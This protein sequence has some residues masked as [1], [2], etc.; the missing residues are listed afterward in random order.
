MR[1]KVDGFDMEIEIIGT[2]EDWKYNIIA[3]FYWGERVRTRL[4]YREDEYRRYLYWREKNQKFYITKE[5]YQQLLK[6]A[7][8]LETKEEHEKKVKEELQQQIKNQTGKL[9]REVFTVSDNWIDY[10]RQYLKKEGIK[11]VLDKNGHIIHDAQIL[12]V[13]KDLGK[14]EMTVEEFLEYWNNKYADEYDKNLRRRKERESWEEEDD[15][16]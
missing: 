10:E 12:Y 11:E 2:R 5:Q 3:E 1:M 7:E 15:D 4:I 14:N 13:L 6:E 16:E 9:I 8:K